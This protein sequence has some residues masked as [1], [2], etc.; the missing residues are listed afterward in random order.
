MHCQLTFKLLQLG[1]PGGPLGCGCQRDQELRLLKRL[2]P[3]IGKARALENAVEGV[4]VTLRDGIKFVVMTACAG[5]GKPKR[6]L[7]CSVDN[8]LVGEVH[9][10]ID[11]VSKPPCASEKTGRDT[12]IA[13]G[14]PCELIC[15]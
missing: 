12:G 10:G 11:V 2:T 3:G 1:F 8:I 15:H 9:I 4:V 14:I 13:C 7:A 5:K 6:G